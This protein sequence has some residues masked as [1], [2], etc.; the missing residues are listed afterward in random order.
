MTEFVRPIQESIEDFLILDIE[1]LCD[2][3]DH[4]KHYIPDSLSESE[5]HATF[6]S[7]LKESANGLVVRKPSGGREQIVLYGRDSSHGNLRGEVSHLVFSE[8]EILLALLKDYFQRPAHRVN[9]IG[10]KEIYLAVGGDES[11]PLAPLVALGEKQTDVAACKDHV[12]SYVPTAQATA[13]LASLLRMVEECDKLVSGVLLTFIYVLRLAHLDH[14][15]VMASD[16][17]GRDKQNDLGTGKPTV[18]QYVVEVYLALDD[19]TYHLNH[20][21]NLALAVLIYTLGGMGVLVVLLGE[22]CVKLLLLQT[23]VALLSCLTDYSE[24]EKYLADAIGN[25]N[26]QALEA[27]HHRMRHMGVYL[28][29]KLRLDAT[30]R[31]VGIID[32]QADGVCAVTCPLL[33]ALV[34]KLAGNGGKNLAPWR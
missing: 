28:A 32:H 5:F 21:R 15:K 17:A 3:A 18:G 27:E 29:D 12:N 23:M 7:I 34:P 20:Q 25:A 19:A 16:V 11:I 22:A 14:A 26:E 31:V 33:L 13:V 10:L 1:T 2:F 6:G 30:L 9:S 4:L 24:V 8:S